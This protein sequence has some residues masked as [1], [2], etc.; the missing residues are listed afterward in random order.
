MNGNISKELPQG[1][2]IASQFVLNVHKNTTAFV[3]EKKSA[4]LKLGCNF[5]FKGQICVIRIE[6]ERHDFRFESQFDMVLTSSFH[7]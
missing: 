7:W 5:S 1:P 3:T 2:I 4:A 6:V